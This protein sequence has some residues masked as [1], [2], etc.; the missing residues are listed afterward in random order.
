MTRHGEETG[1]QA[2]VT[3][4]FSL[5]KIEFLR[6]NYEILERCKDREFVLEQCRT[7]G[8]LRR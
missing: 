1:R 2:V 3:G 4:F 5:R 7:Q 8:L 6:E